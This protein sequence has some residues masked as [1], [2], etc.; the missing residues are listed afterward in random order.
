MLRRGKRRENQPNQPR[1]QGLSL[2]A[3]LQTKESKKA[4]LIPYIYVLRY[5]VNFW[6]IFGDVW[7]AIVF[8]K[9]LVKFRQIRNIENL[10]WF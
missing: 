10:M 9:G 1:S 8:L 4:S 6:V 3:Y 7:E 5:F 2:P